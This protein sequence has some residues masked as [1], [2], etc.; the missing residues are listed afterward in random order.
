MGGGRTC[1]RGPP[2]TFVHADNEGEEGISVAKAVTKRHG[3]TQDRARATRE[4]ILDTAAQLFGERGI[5]NTSTN[6]IA[7]EAE[8]SIGTVYRYF[9]DRDMIVDEL[10]ARMMNTIEYRF[11]EQATRLGSE[12]LPHLVTSIL[13]TLSSELVA[14]APLVGASRRNCSSTA[15]AF[16]ISSRGCGRWLRAFSAGFWVRSRP[17]APTT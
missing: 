15:P 5:A 7:T 3:P 4:R 14:N 17:T 10:L 2:V 9:A 6:R 11:S 8:V 13:E 16:P 1:D 12:P